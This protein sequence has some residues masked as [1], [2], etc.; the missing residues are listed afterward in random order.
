MYCLALINCWDEESS[1]LCDNL[2][3]ELG[4]SI[5]LDTGILER[6]IERLEE[7]LNNYTVI[8]R[9]HAEEHTKRTLTFVRKKLKLTIAEN[10]RVNNG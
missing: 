1:A 5:D 10:R 7:L 8:A 3:T 9:R 6:V 2:S 4:L